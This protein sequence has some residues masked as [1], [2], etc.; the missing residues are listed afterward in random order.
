MDLAYGWLIKTG[1][2]LTLAFVL[3]LYLVIYIFLYLSPFSSLNSINETMLGTITPTTQEVQRGVTMGKELDCLTRG[4]GNKMRIHLTEGKRRPEAPMQAA[5]LASEGGIALRDHIPIFP[6]WKE[7][8]AKENE[9][10]IDNYI[11]KL[12]VSLTI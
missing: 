4:L 8:K 2:N 10:Q 12:A 9:D 3:P 6:H 5:K 7:Y 11:G 1:S